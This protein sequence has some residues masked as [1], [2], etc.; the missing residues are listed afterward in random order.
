MRH[1]SAVPADT[2]RATGKLAFV[3]D[4]VTAPTN[5]PVIE[6]ALGVAF[7]PLP[8][9]GAIGLARMAAD[10]QD[11]YPNMRE[12]PGRP[13]DRLDVGTIVEFGTGAPP[14]RL[15]LSSSDENYLI[16]VQSDTLI[17][18]WRRIK[19]DDEY[20]RHE[21]LIERFSGLWDEFQRKS[22]RRKSIKPT[23]VEW[24]YVDRLDSAV[25]SSGGLRFIDWSLGTDLPG[26][27]RA[28]NFQIVRELRERGKREGYLSITGSPVTTP[29]SGSFYGLT[30]T[31]KLNAAGMPTTEIV[32]RLKQAHDHGYEAFTTVVD[33]ALQGGRTT[34]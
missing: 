26:V 22:A 19:D 13:P 6:V 15:W 12:V 32:G 18:N 2:G 29:G 23:L 14:S 34:T 33:P 3:P 30:I 9:L 25:L 8:E 4:T 16:Q 5:A 21:A 10:W 31:T 27:Q 24:T 7:E 17:I 1:F 20:P 28:F 11:E